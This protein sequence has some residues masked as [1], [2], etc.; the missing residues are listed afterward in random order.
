[1]PQW[2][3]AF[4]PSKLVIIN[5]CFTKGLDDG[6]R[7]IFL[8]CFEGLNFGDGVTIFS[9]S[10]NEAVPFIAKAVK[11]I[12][13]A[14]GVSGIDYKKLESSQFDSANMSQENIVNYGYKNLLLDG[15]LKTSSEEIDRTSSKLDPL[16]EYNL[17]KY[18]EIVSVTNDRFARAE[19]CLSQ[20]VPVFDPSLFG[21]QG[22]IMDSW[23]SAE[24]FTE[25][26][27]G[28]CFKI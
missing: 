3:K 19:N 4:L 12:L 17:I 16:S 6:F 9:N 24:A 5:L 1:M 22:K 18:A 20:F 13:R 8:H 11:L 2:G 25:K 14:L 27:R 26:Q 23:E 7:A 15:F 10:D 28:A 21:K